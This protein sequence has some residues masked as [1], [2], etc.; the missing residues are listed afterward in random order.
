MLILL[1]SSWL[2]SNGQTGSIKGK[3]IYRPTTFAHEGVTISILKGTTVI[4]SVVTDEKGNYSVSKIEE[5]KYTVRV[6][7]YSREA[8]LKDAI[9]IVENELKRIDLIYPD[10]CSATEKFC[11][12]FHTNNI[13][14]IVY[15]LPAKALMDRAE[16]GEVHL[17]GCIVTDCDPKWY[18][19]IHKI[20]F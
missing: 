4:A 17:G 15:G 7:E 10:N 9:V 16:R 13:I 20:E 18:C 1:L 11:P 19:T 3:L 14:R 8:L 2:I 12:R 6:R 5:G